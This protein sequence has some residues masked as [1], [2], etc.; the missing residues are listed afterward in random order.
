ML[1]IEFIGGT[2]AGKYRRHL[3]VSCIVLMTAVALSVTAC[4]PAPSVI[5]GESL[6]NEKVALIESGKTTREEM[7][8]IFGIPVAIA[9]YG[10]T[11]LIKQPAHWVPGTAIVPGDIQKLESDSFFELFSQKHKLGPEHRVYHYYYSIS[12]SMATI[13][14]LYIKENSRVEIDKLWVLVNERTGLVQDYFY[15]PFKRK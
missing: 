14:V 8:S 6:G 2:I 1:V 13:I 11:V 9:V 15:K 10:E 3:Y 5:T 4:V 12:T 7:L